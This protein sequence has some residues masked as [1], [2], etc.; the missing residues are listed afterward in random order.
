MA[1]R[2]Q[3]LGPRPPQTQGRARETGRR[4]FQAFDRPCVR[5]WP[6]QSRPHP[7]AQPF[8]RALCAGLVQR[9]AVVGAAALT[10]QIAAARAPGTP[11]R[12]RR[13][14]ALWPLRRA[15][16]TPGARRLGL[17]SCRVF[18]RNP[19][20]SGAAAATAP[21]TARHAA[22]A[23]PRHGHRA[24]SREQPAAARRCAGLA[25]LGHAGRHAPLCAALSPAHRA[26]GGN[27]G[28]AQ[29]GARLP[30][31][32]RAAVPGQRASERQIAAPVAAPG[33]AVA[34]GVS[35]PGRHLAAN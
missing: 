3:R 28:L 5:R 25:A 2:A 19:C 24:R 33:L 15:A 12:P 22:F 10:P 23:H 31:G 26:V 1:C 30:A 7:L 21:G 6:A 27:R 29:S 20:R 16:S 4:S 35:R 8:A 13:G 34:A 18:G 32:R 17:D 14:T 9:R 11:L